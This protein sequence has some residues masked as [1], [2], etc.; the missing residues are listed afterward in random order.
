M[1]ASVSISNQA[2]VFVIITEAAVKQTKFVFDSFYFIL[3]QWIL[4]VN[5]T[6]V[7]ILI[8][9]PVCCCKF[10]FEMKPV[11]VQ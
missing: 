10:Y 11:D 6:K 7:T 8:I 2:G 3:G 1:K 4:G 5:Q 9:T